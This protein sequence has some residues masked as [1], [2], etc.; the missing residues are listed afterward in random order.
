MMDDK[1]ADNE[2]ACGKCDLQQAD[3]TESELQ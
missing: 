1:S 3:I 2:L